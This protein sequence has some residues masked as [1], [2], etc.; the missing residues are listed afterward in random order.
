MIVKNKSYQHPSQT[1]DK[2]ILPAIM[3]AVSVCYRYSL[4]VF[5]EI[6]QPWC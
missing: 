5:Y 3:F 4:M 1:I 6:L 2:F